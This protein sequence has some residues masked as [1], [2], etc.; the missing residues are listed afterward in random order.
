MIDDFYQLGALY[1]NGGSSNYF[2]VL[3]HL[4]KEHNPTFYYLLLFS[5]FGDVNYYS[6][7]LL[8]SGGSVNEGET[9]TLRCGTVGYHDGQWRSK[10]D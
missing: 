8:V 6:P 9:V 5:E 4:L 2:S 1:F 3:S 7:T 10:L